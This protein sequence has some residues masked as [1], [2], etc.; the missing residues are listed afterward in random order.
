[1]KKSFLALAVAA[2][3]A[4]SIASTASATTVYDKDGTSMAVYG[5]VQ[6]VYYSEQQSGVSNDEGSFN[7]SARLGVDVRTPLTSGIAAFAKAEWEGA[8][9]NNKNDEEDGFDARYLWVG[10]DFGQ[11]G[12]VKVGKFEEAIK[13]AIG[14]TDHWED[15]GCTGLA[16]N[17]DRREGVVQY[18]WSGY[19][20]DAFLSYAFAKDNE[21]LDGAYFATKGENV[22]IDYSVS[23]ALGYT[24]PD[25]LF[26]PIGIR[27][28]FLY[29]KFADGDTNVFR[30]DDN[31]NI[32]G[33]AN[34]VYY[35]ELDKNGNTEYTV[36]DD[37][38]QYAVSA[39]WGS[40]AQGPYVAAVYQQREFSGNVM[41]ADRSS[42][43]G[44]TSPDYTVKGYE[45]TC[46]YTFANGLRLATGYEVQNVDFD[47]E[48]DDIK[49][50]TVPVLALWRVNPNFDVWA[51]AR[52]DAGTDDDQSKNGKNFDRDVGTSYAEDFFALGI[53]YNF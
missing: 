2:L 3:A 26:G 10:L 44:A 13:Y 34:N 45:F 19:G 16:G 9:G 14:P 38:T 50:A 8:N 17:D 48:S 28:G 7:S 30:R 43:S 11:F 40:L 47:D 31:G 21:H 46:A 42:V 5:R 12:Q 1:M 15:S 6:S 35:T 32:T 37:Y 27:A 20:V 23:G 24:S 33:G 41:Y 25:V 51:E 39:F 36:Y 49:A 53:R 18:Q 4:T 22:D 29:G 52:F